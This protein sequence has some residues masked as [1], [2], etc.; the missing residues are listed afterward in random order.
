MNR[1]IHGL[2]G[3][4]ALAVSLASGCDQRS[5]GGS[6]GSGG[7]SCSDFCSALQDGENCSELDR[8]DCTQECVETSASCEARAAELLECLTKL[9]Y[10]CIADGYAVATGDTDP[11]TI[12]TLYTG[13]ST[14][15]VHDEACGQL[16]IAFQDCEVDPSTSTA[17]SASSTAGSGGSGST[18][19]TTAATSGSGGG[20]NGCPP[21]HPVSCGGTSCWTAD[22]DCA[23]VTV[24]DGD[25]L[26]CSQAETALGKV[27]DCAYLDCVATPTTCTFDAS[28]P[29]FCPG[30]N[31][32][33]PA[34]WSPGTA[35]ATVVACA[36]GN[37]LSCSQP[38]QAIDC[39]AEQCLSP[40]VAESTDA[41]CSSAADEDGNGFENCAD[42]HCLSNPSI[43]VCDGENDEA[44]CSNGIDDD[45]NGFKDCADYACQASPAV[46]GCAAENS[47]AMCHDGA[48]NDADGKKDC[49]D[50]SCFGSAFVSCP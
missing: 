46:T 20:N 5:G 48:D 16:T 18:T 24:C 3:S 26:A 38:D 42:F 50:T 17:T 27:V 44:A 25:E 29:T 11:G 39:A 14:L 49:V 6:G 1:W 9:S 34:C 10:S 32:T 23:S 35:C 13:S 30:R 19:S 33:L 45:G 15:E 31:G 8:T 21:D 37:W 43:T 36:S 22:V 2:L 28:Y 4:F 41:A 7:A 12:A 47:E 40:T